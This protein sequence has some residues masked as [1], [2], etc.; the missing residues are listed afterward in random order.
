MTDRP[1]AGRLY[2]KLAKI[3]NNLVDDGLYAT[4]VPVKL[5][6]RYW[7]FAI[8]FKIKKKSSKINSIP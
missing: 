2:V 1:E 3:I 5:I 8:R 7:L 6:N 4:F